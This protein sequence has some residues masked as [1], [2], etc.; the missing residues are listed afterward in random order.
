MMLVIS[1]IG[2]NMHRKITVHDIY[3]IIGH[4]VLR[5]TPY[6]RS[7]IR[8]MD[9][10]AAPWLRQDHSLERGEVAGT[11]AQRRRRGDILDNGQRVHAITLEFTI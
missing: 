4:G 10:R 6:C 9:V 8:S 5:D 1:L 7:T 3:V 2:E 11:T